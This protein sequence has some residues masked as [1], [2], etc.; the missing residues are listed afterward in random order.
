MLWRNL[1]VPSLLLSL[2][3]CWPAQ[4]SGHT[5]PLLPPMKSSS[6]LLLFLACSE[7]HGMCAADRNSFLLVSRGR[8]FLTATPSVRFAPPFL[9]WSWNGFVAEN[10]LAG[11]RLLV[12]YS[13]QLG[14]FALFVLSLPPADPW[15]RV[16]D[17]RR[18]GAREEG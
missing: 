12:G 4:H 18:G 15:N 6:P 1:A 14:L 17:S 2:P 8:R 16:S 7:C 9:A 11:K 3:S 5:S 10:R 13:F